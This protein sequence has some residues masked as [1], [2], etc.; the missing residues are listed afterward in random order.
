MTR[1]TSVFEFKEAELIGCRFLPIIPFGD[2]S[3]IWLELPKLTDPVF[4]ILLVA[5][6]IFDPKEIASR[7]DKL[8]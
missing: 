3:R 7:P 5:T 6:H 2:F 1:V 4:C 8:D